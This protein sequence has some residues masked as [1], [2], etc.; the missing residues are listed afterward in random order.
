MTV[1][2]YASFLGLAR[3]DRRDVF[4]AAARRLDTLPDF[5]EKDFWVCLVLDI[6]FNRMPGIRPRILFKGGTSLSKGFGLIRRFSEDIDLVVHRGDLGFAGEHDPTAAGALSNKRRTAL[7]KE[8]VLACSAHVQG[9]MRSALTTATAAMEK[10]CT[11][12]PEDGD[13]QTLLVVYPGLWPGSETAYVQPRI[14]IEAGARSALEPAASR[15]IVPYIA[16]DLPNWRF[17]VTGITMLT[18]ERT[19]LEKL[20]ILHGIHCGYRD[21]RRLPADSD[22]ISRHYYD[23]AMMAATGTGTAALSDPSL[24]DRVREHNLT[25][26][27]QAWKRFEEAVPGSLRMIPQPE[28]MAVIE[29]DYRSMRGMILGDA[30]PFAWIMQQLQRVEATINS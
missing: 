24:L 29:R 8:L 10:G 7:F 26:F 25:A 4:A 23:V 14:R 15:S 5:V 17:T 28:P 18:P 30:P 22:R 11:V 21:A 12:I 3:Q 13:D 20:L 27:R 6:L 19:F 1:D 9:P 2:G 16:D